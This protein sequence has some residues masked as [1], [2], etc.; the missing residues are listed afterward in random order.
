MQSFAAISRDPESG[1]T[2]IASPATKAD[3]LQT[4]RV[5]DAVRRRKVDGART[6][7]PDALSYGDFDFGPV[8]ASSDGGDKRTDLR[9]A[10]P[11]L[12]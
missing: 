9:A 11:I 8:R 6:R 1:R 5:S 12:K 10:R 4:F 3:L 2:A 7:G